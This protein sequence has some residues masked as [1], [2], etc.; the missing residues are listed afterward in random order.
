MARK[1]LGENVACVGSNLAYVYP[2][3]T[4][5]RADIFLDEKKSKGRPRDFRRGENLPFESCKK[6]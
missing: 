1:S 3:F 6:H 2:V 5:G 4:G